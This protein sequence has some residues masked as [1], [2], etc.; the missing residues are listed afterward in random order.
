MLLNRAFILFLNVKLKS[1]TNRI[2]LSFWNNIFEFARN[3]LLQ[4]LYNYNMYILWK[5]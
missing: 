5:G 2:E 4:T 1:A 3:L